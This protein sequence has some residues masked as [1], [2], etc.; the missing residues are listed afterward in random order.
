LRIFITIVL[1][2]IGIF[3]FYDDSDPFYSDFDFQCRT[4]P[5]IKPS[6]IVSCNGLDG[7]WVLNPGYGDF[8]EKLESLD[9]IDSIIVGKYYNKYIQVPE[10]IDTT[11]FIFDTKQK[12]TTSFSNEL[13]FNT[14][15]FELTNQKADFRL[16]SDLY[17][18]LIDKKY[19][20]W[21]PDEYKPDKQ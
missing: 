17:L 20:K 3:C 4:V 15:L 2:I 5:L 11:W 14:S 12:I 19:L 8:G 18:E 7:M 21:F 9:V 16:V 1:V 6:K 10:N 13:D